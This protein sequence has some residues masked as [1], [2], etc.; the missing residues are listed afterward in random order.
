MGKK[1]KEHKKRVAKRNANLKSQENRM[2]KLWQDAF[3]VQ[4]DAMKEKYANMSG[5]TT[6][7]DVIN[8]AKLDIVNDKLNGLE[9]LINNVN[10]DGNTDD[11]QS[12]L[13]DIANILDINLNEETTQEVIES[14]EPTQE[15]QTV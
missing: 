2:Q 9:N 12:T 15:D 4:M 14:V 7:D 8:E 6:S 3:Q 10:D 5:D 11:I 13:K 1:T